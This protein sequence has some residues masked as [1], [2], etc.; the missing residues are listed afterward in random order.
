[1]YHAGFREEALQEAKTSNEAEEEEA[2]Y[3]WSSGGRWPYNK[4]SPEKEEVCE[5]Y[6]RRANS[7]FLFK[8]LLMGAIIFRSV[9]PFCITV[10]TGTR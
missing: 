9:S 4:T 3:R 1:M 10:H 8:L 2:S 5:L 7:I 6:R